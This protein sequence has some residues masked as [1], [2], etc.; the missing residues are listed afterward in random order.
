MEMPHKGPPIPHPLDSPGL[1]ASGLPHALLFAF[2]QGQVS[3]IAA[4]LRAPKPEHAGSLSSP[5][6]GGLLNEKPKGAAFL[7]I[8]RSS[9]GGGWAEES[10]I[11]DSTDFLSDFP[12]WFGK[13]HE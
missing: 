3:R 2:R 1:P 8:I 13:L 9:C 10:P 7:Q 11:C 6:T 4:H 12:L 5:P